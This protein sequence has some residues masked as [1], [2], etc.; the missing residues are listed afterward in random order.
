MEMKNKIKSLRL[1]EGLSQA[2]FCEKIAIPLNILKKYE[3]G[4]IQP[5]F[6][7]LIKVTQHPLFEKYT[8]WL[9]TEKTSEAAGQISPALS[10]N[11]QDDIFKLQIT[12]AAG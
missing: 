8:L 6:L 5:D 9:M 4:W 1:A 3:R 10:P 2:Q 7:S 11:G 12:Q